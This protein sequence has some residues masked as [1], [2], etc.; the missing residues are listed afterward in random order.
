P[1]RLHDRLGA[2][3]FRGSRTIEAGALGPGDTMR[4]VACDARRPPTATQLAD[5]AAP[6]ESI[7]EAE[8]CHL[9]GAPLRRRDARGC[10]PPDHGA[11]PSITAGGRRWIL[12]PPPTQHLRRQWLRPAP[13]CSAPRDLLPAGRGYAHEPQ[14][15]PQRR[16]VAEQW[17]R[18]P[19]P[20]T[21]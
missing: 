10:H 1:L 15:D 11:L 14:R 21:R 3:G 9:P 8:V 13:T 18:R 6:N 2:A 16:V 7:H 17:W 19:R 4:Y 5:I 12:G 20:G